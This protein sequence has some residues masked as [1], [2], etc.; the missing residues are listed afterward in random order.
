MNNLY[1]LRYFLFQ[2]HL[3]SKS[4]TSFAFFFYIICR[5]E[6]LPVTHSFTCLPALFYLFFITAVQHKK[7]SRPSFRKAGAFI[8][9]MTIAFLYLADYTKP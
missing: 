3:S 7:N 2:V 1:N 6:V 8:L 4:C 5:N 9:K